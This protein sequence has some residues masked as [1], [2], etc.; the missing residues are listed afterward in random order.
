[1]LGNH[2]SRGVCITTEDRQPH[3]VPL[4]PEGRWHGQL[5]RPWEKTPPLQ[6]PKGRKGRHRGPGE[7]WGTGLAGS[8]GGSSRAG[9]EVDRA[10]Q[11][12]EG[13]SVECGRRKAMTR[14]RGWGGG[15]GGAQAEKELTLGLLR[16]QS[17]G[18][19][20]GCAGGSAGSPKGPGAAARDDRNTREG[21]RE[22]RKFP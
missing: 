10:R 19:A 2:S 20:C 1:M 18:R 21:P 17:C 8:P 7:D 14:R 15:C 12:R 16:R 3:E 13:R 5:R 4:L 22:G 11:A 9:G 6:R